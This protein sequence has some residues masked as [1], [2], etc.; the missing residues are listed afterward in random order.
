MLEGEEVLESAQ[1]TGYRLCV[2][3]GNNGT[4]SD[5]V[6]DFS[7]VFSCTWD[8]NNRDRLYVC[9]QKGSL[10][11]Y[12]LRNGDT[13]DFCVLFRRFTDT[14]TKQ[15]GRLIPYHWDKMIPIPDRPDEFIFCLGVTRSLMYSALPGSEPYPEEPFISKSTRGDFTG[16]IYGTPVMELWVHPARVT[17]VAVAQSGQVLA[18]G[19]E[20]GNLKL[21]MLRLLD[22]IIPTPNNA[23]KAATKGDT[24]GNQVPNFSPFLPE[25]K[26]TLRAHDSGPIFS[27]A[28][29]PMPSITAEDSVDE[30]LGD[31]AG[32]GKNKSRYYA[33]ATGSADRCVKIWGISCSMRNGLVATPIMT[34]DTLSTHVLSLSAFLKIEPISKSDK[35]MNKQG[36]MKFQTGGGSSI[37][38]AAGTNVGAIY[39]WNLST[40]EVFG[41]THGS[42]AVKLIDDGSKLHSLLQTSDRPIVNLSLS[43]AL[44]PAAKSTTTSSSTFGHKPSMVLVASDTK[45]TVRTHR[46][47]ND[48]PKSVYENGGHQHGSKNPITLCGEASYGSSMIVSASFQEHPNNQVNPKKGDTWT[49]QD[50]RNDLILG[51]NARRWKGSRMLIATSDGSVQIVQTDD[52]MHPTSNENPVN[53]LDTDISHHEHEFTANDEEEWDEDSEYSSSDGEIHTHEQHYEEQVEALPSKEKKNQVKNKKTKKLK[54]VI[55]AAAIGS[56][57]VGGIAPGKKAPGKRVL[58]VDTSFEEIPRSGSPYENDAAPAIKSSSVTTSKSEG[59]VTFGSPTLSIEEPREFAHSPPYDDDGNTSDDSD[60]APRAAPTSQIATSPYVV[61]DAGR[62]PRNPTGSY[63]TMHAGRTPKA[64]A[65]NT[66]NTRD[67]GK[68]PKA[69]SSNGGTAEEP[70]AAWDAGNTPEAKV[71]SAFTHVASTVQFADESSTPVQKSKEVGT[72]KRSKTAKPTAARAPTRPVPTSPAMAPTASSRARSPITIVETRPYVNG[73]DSEEEKTPPPPPPPVQKSSLSTADINSSKYLKA[74][75]LAMKAK[76]DNDDISIG[77]LETTDSDRMDAM[78]TVLNIPTHSPRYNHDRLTRILDLDDP[79]LFFV[80]ERKPAVIH[81]S[82]DPAWLHRKKNMGP[83]ISDLQPLYAP[84]PVVYLSLDRNTNFSSNDRDRV[85]VGG[86]NDLQYNHDTESFY[87]QYTNKVQATD[88]FG[89]LYS[90]M[91]LKQDQQFFENCYEHSLLES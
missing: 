2:S 6:D 82:T 91:Q 15:E 57:N 22:N 38:L 78:R 73:D 40:T 44:D 86:T 24:N 23:K 11:V 77:T 7:K 50:C 76:I 51:D 84:D 71:S 5:Q 61:Q 29:L 55:A 79:D 83:S 47:S 63:K 8:P 27:V 32:Y 66:F 68:T 49:V 60:S 45:G 9:S 19:D 90:D 18:S 88:V 53:L 42:K 12:N 31:D 10:R 25:Y 16:Y 4:E 36:A 72:T 21:L 87:P 75:M 70:F 54:N 30:D 34:L 14:D 39:V 37:Y 69:P 43:L 89:S 58:H 64:G 48:L 41:A 35:A 59:T 85:C 28:W 67:A 62:T 81:K 33:L 3:K 56:G 17:A 80:G 65:S 20:Q 13:R 52:A 74:Q 1:E 26:C 46:Q